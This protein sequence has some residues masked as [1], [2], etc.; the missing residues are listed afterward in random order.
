MLGPYGSIPTNSDLR[1]RLHSI[2]TAMMPPPTQAPCCP[3]RTQPR[4]QRLLSEVFASLSRCGGAAVD[5]L[6]MVTEVWAWIWVTK[7]GS[8][9]DLLSTQMCRRRLWDQLLTLS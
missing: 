1:C 4:D 7:Q 2:D 3:R 9:H 8:L 6:E 5:L